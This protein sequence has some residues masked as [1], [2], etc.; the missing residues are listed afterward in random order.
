VGRDRAELAHELRKIK[1]D[2]RRQQRRDVVM[3]SLQRTWQC[4]RLAM[5]GVVRCGPLLTRDQVCFVFCIFKRCLFAVAQHV[6]YSWNRHRLAQL[7]CRQCWQPKRPT[8]ECYDG[9]WL[10]IL[11]SIEIVSF[12]TT[13]TLIVLYRLLPLCVRMACDVTASLG[14]RQLL[15]AAVLDQ[16]V[17]GGGASFVGVDD[18]DNTV[19]DDA[20][21]DDD[22]ELLTSGID[23]KQSD[24]DSKSNANNK[25]K[26]MRAQTRAHDALIRTVLFNAAPLLRLVLGAL[27]SRSSDI[28]ARAA[29]TLGMSSICMCVCLH[30]QNML[31]NVVILARLV[32]HRLG[33]DDASKQTSIDVEQRHELLASLLALVPAAQCKAPAVYRA[34]AATASRYHY[35]LRCCCSVLMI[36]I[37]F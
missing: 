23:A 15:L 9:Y 33:L 5:R 36:K 21:D 17:C 22:N 26:S 13:T 10:I 18:D 37:R 3:S 34:A 35:Y 30:T 1:D 19:D 14:D 2:Q 25:Q 4:A 16:F 12:T 31:L 24:V 7:Y 27:L 6:L 20:D 11:P 29:A 32:P 28:R 8:C